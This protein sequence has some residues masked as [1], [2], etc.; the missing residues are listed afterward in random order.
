MSNIITAAN[1]RE[2]LGIGDSVDDQSIAWAVAAA[3]RQ[4]RT[5]C[6]RSFEVDAAQSATA[7]Y[8]APLSP[9]QVMI[10]DAWQITQIAT[11]DNDNGTW[12]AV[13]SSGDWFA[14]PSGGI[15]PDGLSGW[16]YTEIAAVSTLPL[17]PPAMR[18]SVKVTAKWGWTALPDDVFLA[19]LMVGAELFRAKSGGSDVFTA[20]GQ[21]VPIRRNAVLR[22]LLAPYRGIKAN[23]TRFVVG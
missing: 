16:P 1:L 12:S 20:D 2:H 21:F 9:Y 17:F 11:D 14:H 15:G 19:T 13:W 7:R 3:Q 10:D 18:P 22:D 8:F 6:G 4:V 23:D 5:Y